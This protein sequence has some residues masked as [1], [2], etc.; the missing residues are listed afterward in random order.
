MRKLSYSRSQV[1]ELRKQIEVNS[2][3]ISQLEN[4][5]NSRMLIS[6]GSLQDD[7]QNKLYKEELI[8]YAITRINSYL[9]LGLNRQYIVDCYTLKEKPWGQLGRTMMPIVIVFVHIPMRNHISSN[10]RFF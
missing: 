5:D 10:K 4:L 8:D 7:C 9:R 1:D 3:K 6:H 2:L